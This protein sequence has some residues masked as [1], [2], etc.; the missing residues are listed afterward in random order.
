MWLSLRVQRPPVAWM[1]RRSFQVRL[2]DQCTS[3]SCLCNDYMAVPTTTIRPPFTANSTAV[4]RVDIR[5]LATDANLIPDA[6][7]I[8]GPSRL[9]RFVCDFGVLA[10]HCGS[11]EFEDTHFVARYRWK[12][13]ERF[14]SHCLFVYSSFCCSLLLYLFGW[15]HAQTAVV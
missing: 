13:L 1:A 5:W 14:C 15:M 7:S 8:F 4:R 2:M 3:V 10:G 12:M 11:C 6:C 9:H